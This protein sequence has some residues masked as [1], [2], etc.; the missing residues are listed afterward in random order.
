M[1]TSVREALQ[2]GD[3]I[4]G[5]L[6]HEEKQFL[7]EINQFLTDDVPV[8]MP[9]TIKALL[10]DPEKDAAVEGD[11]KSGEKAAREDHKDSPVKEGTARLEKGGVGDHKEKTVTQ[12]T[13]TPEKIST[14]KQNTVI[15]EKST[16]KEDGVAQETSTPEKIST[17]KQ[18]TV[19]QEKS[20]VK[21]DSVAQEK[22]SGAEVKEDGMTGETFSV[23]SIVSRDM[24]T[25]DTV[26]RTESKN[27]TA[28]P[29]NQNADE[30]R[31]TDK[32]K[33]DKRPV[34]TEVTGRQVVTTIVKTPGTPPVQRTTE[35][36]VKNGNIEKE[37]VLAAL[38]DSGKESSKSHASAAASGSP[39]DLGAR[40][41]V[42]RM[43]PADISIL[44]SL[45]SHEPRPDQ[46]SPAAH[47][48]NNLSA[49]DTGDPLNRSNLPHPYRS[50]STNLSQLQ[51]LQNFDL[52]SGRVLDPD[53]PFGR[54]NLRQ[55]LES[56]S[57]YERDILHRYRSSLSFREYLRQGYGA[58]V[59]QWATTLGVH[60]SEKKHLYF[61]L[62]RHLNDRLD[63]NPMG[64]DLDVLYYANKFLRG[65]DGNSAVS[66]VTI[67]RL[68]SD[69]SQYLDVP[70]RT[71]AKLVRRFV[72]PTQ[73]P[74][75]ALSKQDFFARLDRLPT[76]SLNKHS[77][78]VWRGSGAQSVP[79]YEF[80]PAH[81]T[82]GLSMAPPTGQHLGVKILQLHG[83]V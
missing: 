44:G 74:L 13:S 16:V 31:L 81:L 82:Y 10:S 62:G 60:G 61:M 15:Q 46:I 24:E 2:L 68:V 42:G 8:K 70:S 47:S 9:D 19:I 56:D 7:Q 55:R 51:A 43:P 20:T 36:T 63:G 38:G 71:V 21:E 75:L 39:A 26:L 37:T 76:E 12:E 14:A 17:A 5:D 77:Q 79:A 48:G 40:L 23:R 34:P 28:V 67:N 59:E 32:V 6:Q 33:E 11:E 69:I 80:E 35:T 66:S 72:L 73:R 57:I 50:Y 1:P 27:S 29:E 53:H 54:A 52:P 78:D 18:N 22:I 49:A 25:G 65:I 30:Q 41:F 83:Y 45:A 4:F 58:Y 64:I 3:D